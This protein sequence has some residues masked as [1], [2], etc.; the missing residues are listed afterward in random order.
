MEFAFHNPLFDPLSGD[1]KDIFPELRDRAQYVDEHGYKYFLLNDHLWQIGVIGG[2]EAPILEAYVTLAAVAEATKNIHVGTLVT[3]VNYRNPALLAKMIATMD[4]NSGGRAFLGMG[5]G[6]FEEEYVGYGY[7][8][9]PTKAR[10]QELREALQI[11]KKLWTEPAATYE[12]E[13]HSIANA[14]LEPKP[15]QKPRPK[16]MIGGGGPKVTMR[17]AAEEADITNQVGHPDAFIAAQAAL[18]AHCGAI[19]RDYAE[20]ERTKTENVTLAATQEQA[21]EKWRSFGAPMRGNWKTCVGTPDDAIKLVRYYEEIGVDT[22]VV[23]FHGNDRESLEL[24]TTEVKP[25]F[26]K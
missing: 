1:Q 13:Y 2:S 16:I 12:G 21:D 14:I 6:W 25:A 3:C 19:G 20:I 15:L 10:F 8:F 22:L 7:E 18:K 24:F 17:I 4:V 9:P 23:N 5:A 11:V 26:A